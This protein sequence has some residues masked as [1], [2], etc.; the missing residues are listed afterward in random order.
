[1]ECQHFYSSFEDAQPVA[2]LGLLVMK[3]AEEL[4]KKIDS[5]LVSWY[6]RD[7]GQKNAKFRKI[8]SL[9]NLHVPDLQQEMLR[10]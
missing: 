10:A 1:M 2:P 4:G 8:H 6:N 3:G 5:Y 9:L 7:I